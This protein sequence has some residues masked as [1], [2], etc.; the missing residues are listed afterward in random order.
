MTKSQSSKQPLLKSN[1]TNQKVSAIK[2]KA[3]HSS[4]IKL[5]K[6][7]EKLED[8]EDL[9]YSEDDP[10]EKFLWDKGPKRCRVSSA[11]PRHSKVVPEPFKMTIR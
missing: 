9:S 4:D 5:T 8:F 7:S 1:D 11:P 2:S 10:G 6:W 3:F